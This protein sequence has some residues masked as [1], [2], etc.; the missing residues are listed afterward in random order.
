MLTTLKKFL[1]I[2][3]F[4]AFI[5]ACR[6]PSIP[7][8]PSTSPPVPA[9]TNT[10]VLPVPV[11]PGDENP[12]EP[13]FISGDIPYTS[14]FFLNTISQ[15][16]VMLEDQAGFVQRDLEFEFALKSQ[17]IGPVE[18]HED[19]TIS[20]SL[21]L[22]AV[23]QGTLID[24]DNDDQG[25]AG[26]QIFAVAY[27][28]N[29]WRDPFLEE[30]DGTG[31]S[32]AYA[33][34][35][36]DPENDDEIVGGILVVW[37]PD[38]QQGF[39]T[40]FGEDGL[41]FTEDDPTEPIPAGYNLVDLNQEP[42]QVTK[43]AQPTITLNEGV[44]AVNDYSEMS[45]SDA[46]QSLFDKASIE[47]PFTVEKGIDWT[48]LKEEYQ[49]R[50]D[51]ARTNN[52]FYLALKEFS[53]NIPDNHV[54][55][56]FNPDVFLELYGGGFGLVLTELSD[57]Q[58]IVSEV[59][60]GTPAGRSSI[61]EGAEIIN[62]N[63]MPVAEAIENVVPFF[64]PYSTS[65][66]ERVGKVN[67]LTRVPPGTQVDITFKNLGEE[68]EVQESLTADIEYD[69][70]FR[71]IP[72]FNL[73]PLVL[74]VEGHVLD[75]SGFGYIRINS[76]SDD[77]QL[78]ARL[79][80]HYLQN[81]IDEEVPGLVIDLRSNS[82][83]ALNLAMDFAGYFFSEPAEL[84]NN[85][86]YSDLT[87]EFEESDRPTEIKPAPMLYEGPIAVLVSTDCISAC[88]GFAYALQ[89][90]GRS[91]V[92]GHYPTAGAFGEVGQ[93]QYQLPDEISMQFPTGR[94]ETSDGELV[95]EGEGV[96]PD[97]VVPITIESALGQVDALLDAAIQSLRDQIG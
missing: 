23:P 85:Y 73:D 60:V 62:W 90:G 54:N 13:V 56:T 65:H 10:P 67:F 89:H 49:S 68:A 44:I 24:V 69:S 16:F 22:P 72:S 27:W 66:A 3:F 12:D 28:S 93:G 7:T 78:L 77:Y 97:I 40:G 31:W 55:I 86:Y 84:Y 4:I 96:I 6:E 20:Y 70:L 33:S 38:D 18:V 59:L 91:V 53:Y 36:T 42:F 8:N 15:P 52:E 51:N 87:G 47:Y 14:P 74:P 46:F 95:I 71:T 48:E 57:G 58:V 79:W 29:T 75:G 81:L 21:A 88:E 37:A 17:T 9:D 94:P 2:I 64:G 76:F 82:G 61:D 43:E 19:D 30:R 83:G 35:I 41:L 34:T 25:D 92:I 5:A 50:I 11:D 80:D 45:Y 1:F 32:T 63:G 39:P 26:V